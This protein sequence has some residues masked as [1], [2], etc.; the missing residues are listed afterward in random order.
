M[1]RSAA[2]LD[3]DGTLIVEHRDWLTRPEHVRLLPG[4][5]EAVRLLNQAG[6]A[7]IVVTNQSGIGRGFI[8][9]E[10][11]EAVHHEL[12][13]QLTR[14]GAVIDAIYHCPHH[15]TEGIGVLR[16][17]CECRKPKQGMIRQAQV[18]L[19]LTLLESVVIGDDVRD[20]QLANDND[21][22]AILVR[23]GKGAMKE[24]EVIRE[25]GDEVVV[26]DGV[27]AAVEGFLG[28]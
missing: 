4:A 20:V 14:L 18:D 25:L 10:Q 11:L 24:A 8:S 6:L 9:E 1:T 21:L 12:R 19:D 13:S 26:V 2:F 5:A 17:D 23:T 22:Q 16:L 3:R 15:P 27:L 7:V 28:R